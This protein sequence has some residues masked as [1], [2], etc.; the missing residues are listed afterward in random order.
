MD[1]RLGFAAALGSLT[2]LI[3]GLKY[4]GGWIRTFSSAGPGIWALVRVQK[5]ACYFKLSHQFWGLW[6]TSH[7]VTLGY[8]P[9]G[10]LESSSL[11]AFSTLRSILALMLCPWVFR[12]G[13]F[14]PVKSLLPSPRLCWGRPSC[15][16][17]PLLPCVLRCFGGLISALLPAQLSH[18]TNSCLAPPVEAPRISGKLSLLLL[19]PLVWDDHP[20]MLV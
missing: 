7:A 8:P 12:R 3:T 15:S 9:F 11:P 1:L 20:R 10:S 17:A 18:S 13:H 14:C 2:L 6:G 16:G 5:T 19:S 4:P